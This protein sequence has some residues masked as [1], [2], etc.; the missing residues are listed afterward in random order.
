LPAVRPSPVPA[1][2]APH[3][4]FPR[5]LFLL[6]P[7][8][9]PSISDG[10]CLFRALSDQL[11]GTPSCHLQLR[12]EVCS[13]LVVIALY[14][15]T[16]LLQICE[17]LADNPER[18]RLFV[19]ED[20]GGGFHGHV[21]SMRLPGSLLLPACLPSRPRSLTL[22]K[23]SPGTYGT[24]IELSAFAHRYCRSIKVFQPGL[25]YVIRSEREATSGDLGRGGR[26]DAQEGGRLD[27]LTPREQRSRARAAKERD[28]AG[29]GKTT[30]KQNA[31]REMTEENADPLYIMCVS[32][33]WRR[34]KLQDSFLAFL[35][36]DTTA[37][38]IIA[39]CAISQG[40]MR[41]C[42][43]FAK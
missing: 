6:P 34:I 13:P 27:K 39:R 43:P 26:D 11:H 22:S 19:D 33:K 36:L 12:H 29:K 18:Y 23:L 16:R 8:L 30:H 40:P 14:L 42:P 15:S 38:N 1:R 2:F 17:F 28:G 41:A 21:A 20:V 10:N 3:E 7:S 35:S 5:L 24:N 32:L 9:L 25:V 4:H 37:G 31:D